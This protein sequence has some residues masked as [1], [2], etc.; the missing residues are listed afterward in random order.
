MN[1][2]KIALLTEVIKANSNNPHHWDEC[3]NANEKI[4]EL[5]AE[6]Q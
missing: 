5:I 1:A 6:I 4:L 2:L 3:Q